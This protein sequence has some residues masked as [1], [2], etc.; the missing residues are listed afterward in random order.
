VVAIINGQH[1]DVVV[2]I[3]TGL[4]DIVSRAQAQRKIG[5]DI[6]AAAIRAARTIH[7]GRAEFLAVDLL[8]EPQRIK[9]C[10]IDHISVL[11]MINWLH[12]LPLSDIARIV[13]GLR[14]WVPVEFLLIDLIKAGPGFK[15]LH[16]MAECETLGRVESLVPGNDGVRDFALIRLQP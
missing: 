8:Q 5:F 1:P 12:G 9:D 13:Q 3:G 7:R 10:G 15:Y 2:E 14:Q 6:D 16:T 4:G 11:V